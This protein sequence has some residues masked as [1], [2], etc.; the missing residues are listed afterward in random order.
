[1]APSITASA[2]ARHE[3]DA[4][5]SSP[6]TMTRALKLLRDLQWFAIHAKRS[7]EDFAASNIATLGVDVFLPKIKTGRIAG[8]GAPL[9]PGYFF[10]RFCPEQS[11]DGVK[12]AR[13]VL[14]VVGSTHCPI[15]VE[16]EIIAEIQERVQADGFIR[17]G[18]EEWTP[19]TRV[20]IQE[21][22]FEGMMG[23]V[24]RELD[25]AR[26]VAILLETLWQARVVVHKEYL[27]AEM[28]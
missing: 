23:R 25:D 5:G 10:A 22:P 1:M 11:L 21:G 3:P 12:C 8:L 27:Q 17:I 28:A 16:P 9:F 6:D 13:G 15:P 4:A 14:Q 24:E 19:G 20:S 18:R 2:K 7:R 26:R